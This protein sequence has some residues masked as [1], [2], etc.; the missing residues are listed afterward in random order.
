MVSH[1]PDSPAEYMY[2]LSLDFQSTELTR[3]S[4]ASGT[5]WLDN[6][7]YDVELHCD[8]EWCKDETV[9]EDDRGARI[10]H[11]VLRFHGDSLGEIDAQRLA[12]LPHLLTCTL[13]TPDTSES[14]ELAKAVASHPFV[15]AKVRQVSCEEAQ[16]M[17]TNARRGTLPTDFEYSISPLW[18][19]DRY[20]HRR[21]RWSVHLLE[22]PPTLSDLQPQRA[23]QAWVLKL[24]RVAFNFCR[25]AE[26]S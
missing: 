16:D 12:F 24:V 26:R 17:A 15:H 3:Y 18:Y 13:E 8:A 11:V 5:A 14:N 22:S 21:T 7:D 1:R 9:N 19:S 6:K 4:I 2:V 25:R 20:E 10:V 23:L